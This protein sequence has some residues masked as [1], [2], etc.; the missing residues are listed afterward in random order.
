MKI[1]FFAENKKK[2]QVIFELTENTNSAHEGKEF[3]VVN[4]NTD[5]EE[6]NFKN[7]LVADYLHYLTNHESVTDWRTLDTAIAE[8]IKSKV[9][10]I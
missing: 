8:I 6:V 2:N 5:S 9:H 7:G 10:F 4:L 1:K 3:I